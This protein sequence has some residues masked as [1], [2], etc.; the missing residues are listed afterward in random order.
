MIVYVVT[1]E[2]QWGFGDIWGIYSTRELAE[3]RLAAVLAMD[4]SPK[5]E[6]LYIREHSVDDEQVH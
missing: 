5:A 1:R 4:N 2:L 3:T 6:D